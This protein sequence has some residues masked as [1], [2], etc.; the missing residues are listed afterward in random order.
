MEL[1]RIGRQGDGGYL[2]PADLDGIEYCFSPGVGN[3]CDFENHLA[4]LGIKSFLADGSVEAPPFVRPEFS[5]EKKF[6]GAYDNAQV[7][8]L[9]SWKERL[10]GGF[11]GDLMLQMDIEGSEYGVIL[12]TPESLLRQFRTMVI[13]F[14]GLDRLFDPFVL[15]LISASFDKILHQFYVAHIHPNNCCPVVKVGDVEV[16]PALEF[17]FINKRRV[18]STR[19]R[20]DFPHRLDA[21]NVAAKPLYLPKCWYSEV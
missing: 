1:V 7:M 4:D 21:D 20:R 3:S 15:P 5:F 6:L 10:L 12:S 13:E 9:S 18:Q 2:V 11:A 17:T 16:P 14:H 8:T 19:A